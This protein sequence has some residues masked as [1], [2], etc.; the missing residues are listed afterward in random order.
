MAT[1]HTEVI[2]CHFLDEVIKGIAVVSGMEKGPLFEF[3]DIFVDFLNGLFSAGHNR[4]NCPYRWRKRPK[5]PGLFPGKK[6]PAT[7]RDGTFFASGL[8]RF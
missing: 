3:G 8:G 6:I 7:E 4:N 5:I 1:E 2:G